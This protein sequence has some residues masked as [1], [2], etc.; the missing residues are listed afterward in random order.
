[1]ISIAQNAGKSPFPRLILAQD[2][3][4]PG[5]ATRTVSSTKVK[6]VLVC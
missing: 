2:R 4:A 1:M 3:L 6:E 5:G